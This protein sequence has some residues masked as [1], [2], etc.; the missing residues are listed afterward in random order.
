[1]ADDSGKGSIIL[2]TIIVVLIVVLAG[3]IMIPKRMWDKEAENETICHQRM[4]SL[5]SAELLF[6]KYNEAYCPSLDSLLDFFKN[7]LDSF[8]L[9][10]VEL[11][12]FLG[13]ELMKLIGKDSFAILTMDTIKA[14]TAMDDILKTIGIDYFLAGAMC[15]VV[16]KNDRKMA[17]IINP[18]LAENIEDKM[19]PT[20]AIN[21]LVNHFNA[22]DIMQ[23]LNEDDSLAFVLSQLSPTLAMEHYLQ[24]VKQKT[25]LA[26]RIDSFYACFL[27]S[28]DHCPSVHKKYQI[29]IVGST[30]VYS[31]I[32]CP[33]TAEDSLKI[34]NDFWKKKVGG[35]TLKNHGRITKG[36]KSWESD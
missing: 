2:K 26:T 17:A 14:D 5:L 24:S 1:M 13:V 21:E 4:A 33:I 22:Y 35:M 15:K 12:T 3:A 30:I 27:D 7:D 28:L 29:A 16:Q 9:E 11:D 23:T 32:F 36:E 31:D 8:Q 19:A 25:E 18:V 10:F 20:I 34:E 6:Q